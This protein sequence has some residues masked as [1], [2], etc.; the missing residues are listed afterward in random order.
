M[1]KQNLKYYQNT[2]GVVISK[3]FKEK[4]IE[5][6]FNQTLQINFNTPS[7][8]DTDTLGTFSGLIQRKEDPKKTVLKKCLSGLSLIDCNV[9]IAT[10]A[11]FGS[12]PV[13]PFINAH[14]EWMVFVDEIRQFTVFEKIVSTETTQFQEC[15]SNI[16]QAVSFITENQFPQQGVTLQPPSLDN[17][18]AE[19]YY[20]GIQNLEDFQQYFENLKKKHPKVCVTAELRAHM[21]PSRM[22]VIQQLAKKLVNRIM[23]LCPSCQTPGFGVCSVVE[24]LPCKLCGQA[25]S[26]IK[27]YVYLCQKCNYQEQRTNEIESE[28]Q[29]P[30]YCNF[31]N[32]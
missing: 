28:Y 23:T 14:E 24:G 27:A 4:V 2:E 3:H 1:R 11:S 9:G 6:V 29:D 19:T 25:T 21:N 15:F 20:G 31:C 22:E 10:E 18:N 13:I 16:Y 26:G 5:P 8:F 7:V 12:H 32:P 17:L 30:M